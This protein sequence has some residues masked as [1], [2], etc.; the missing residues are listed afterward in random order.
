LTALTQADVQIA[1]DNVEPAFT[2]STLYQ[3]LT[4][5]FQTLH[6]KRGGAEFDYITGEQCVTRLNTVFG[7]GGWYFKITSR[8]IIE[9]ADECLVEGE[10]GAYISDQWVVRT[11]FGSQKLKR[12]RASGTV[13]DIGFDFK[14]ATTDCIK[15]CASLFGV[16]LYLYEKEPPHGE[17]QHPKPTTS[18]DRTR[19]APYNAGTAAKPI[20]EKC[21]E[22]L[23]GIKFTVVTNGNEKEVTW[24]ATQLA[25]KGKRNYA[26]VLCSLHYREAKKLASEAPSQGA[27]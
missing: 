8:E 10:L 25:Q 5:P 19:G 12:S 7:V 18:D 27:D 6:D 13:L 11:Q 24:T 26:A 23:K 22:A 20:C 21:G 1:Q 15:K 2:P 16:A 4:A 9:I 14:G 3:Q 17:A